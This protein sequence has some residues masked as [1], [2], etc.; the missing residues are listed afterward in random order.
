MEEDVYLR[1]HFPAIS[2]SPDRQPATLIF[3]R[4]IIQQLFLAWS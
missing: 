2:H 4:G 1:G 3:G